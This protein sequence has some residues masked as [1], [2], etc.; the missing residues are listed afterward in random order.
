M[1]NAERATMMI[2]QK[3]RDIGAT[4]GVRITYS[5][6]A[7]K[8]RNGWPLKSSKPYSIRYDDGTLCASFATLAALERNL[9]ER[10][11]C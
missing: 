1:T 7:A 6:Y 10:A 2:P 9:R 11:G 3:L 4:V 8:K 5:K